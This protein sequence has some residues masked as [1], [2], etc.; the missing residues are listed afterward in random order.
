MV[1]FLFLFMMGIDI[2]TINME[3]Q[4]ADLT[5]LQKQRDKVCSV[6]VHIIP[7]VA[8]QDKERNKPANQINP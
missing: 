8:L 2:D 6:I 4:L 7:V 5:Q 3:L 1:C